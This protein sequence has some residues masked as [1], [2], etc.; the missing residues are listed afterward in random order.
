MTMLTHLERGRTL[1]T[2][3]NRHPKIF[4]RLFVSIVHVGENTGKLDD[5]FK[6]LATY[7]ERD[8]E[9]QKQIKVATRYPSFVLIAIALA[10]LIMNYKVIPTLPE[11]SQN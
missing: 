6:Q 3:L 11:C 4:D 9:T 5:A 2:C 7:I 1:S 10:L 8:K